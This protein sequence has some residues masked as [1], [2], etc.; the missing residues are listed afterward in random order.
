MIDRATEFHG[1]TAETEYL[2]TGD[3]ARELIERD[4][5]VKVECLNKD[6]IN[7]LTKDKTISLPKNLG[8]KRTDIAITDEVR[9]PY[10]LIEVK[11]RIK[12][13]TGVEEDLSKLCDTLRRLSDKYSKSSWGVSLFQVHLE[14]TKKRAQRQHFIRDIRRL[15]ARLDKDLATYARSHLDFSFEWCALQ[16]G[17]GGIQ[18]PRLEEVVHD[19][20]VTEMELVNDGF[21]LRY[22][23]V[24][25]QRR[26]RQSQA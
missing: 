8:K 11:I 12:R 15:E 23:A 3:I 22:Y 13:L 1:G 14:K 7:V 10:A 24:L 5:K 26:P 4:Y 18:G 21:A 16:E 9:I 25:V 19:D 17:D 2:L 6:L 20:G